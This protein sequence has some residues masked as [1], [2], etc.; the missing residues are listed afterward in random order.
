MA[1]ETLRADL[2]VIGAG[3]AGLTVS[4]GAAMLGRKVVLF[5]AGEMG[6]DCLNTGCVPSKA[7]LTA[8]H[9]AKAVREGA[10]M[11]VSAGEPQIDFAAVMAHVRRAIAAIEPNDSQERFEG[12]GVR[13]LRERARFTGPDRVESD[14]VI[15]EAKRFVIAAGARAAIPP[16]PGLAEAGYLTNETIWALEALPKRLAI[17][18]GGPIGVELGQAFARLG[19]T[20]TIIEAAR[21]LAGFE[22]VHAAKVRAALHADGVEICEDSRAARVEREGEMIALHLEDGRRVEADHLLVA[23]GRTPNVEGLGLEAAGVDHDRAGVICDDK[24]RTSNR[25]VYAAG[26]IAGK[27]ALTHLAGWHGSVILRNLYFA[28]PTRQSSAAIPAA[29]YTEPTLA[30][31]G[32]TEA[33]ARERYGDKV[34]TAVWGFDDNDR[35]LAEGE[36]VGGAKLVI[37]PGAKLLGVHVAGD[38]ADDIVQLATRAVQRRAKVRELTEVIA[39]YPTRGEVLKRAAGRHYEPVVFGRL[40]KLWA[41]LLAQFH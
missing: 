25:R 23:T 27:G 5:E 12:L 35:A 31:V 39:P 9:H 2:C 14:S 6:G 28:A 17:L 37:G 13:V 22:P 3:A 8:A 1:K 18:G 41:G 24:L 11:G 16:I 26:D 7:L 30:S 21:L 38:R 40:A 15:V 34:R 36:A 4:A 19:S 33:Q 10:R 32:L 29:V 20:V